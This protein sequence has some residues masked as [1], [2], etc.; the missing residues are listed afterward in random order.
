[1]KVEL[2]LV[3]TIKLRDIDK[4]WNGEISFLVS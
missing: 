2:T 1:M 3:Y 4:E